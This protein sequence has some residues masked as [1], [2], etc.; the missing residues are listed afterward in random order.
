MAVASELA[1]HGATQGGVVDEQASVV[2]A[3]HKFL[4]VIE[5]YVGE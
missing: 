2:Y 4:L 1:A 5:V 3:P